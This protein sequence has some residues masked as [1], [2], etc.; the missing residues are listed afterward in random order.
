[1]ATTTGTCTI[2]RLRNGDTIYATLKFNR[3]TN[4]SYEGSIITGGF[5]EKPLVVEPLFASASGSVVTLKTGVWKCDDVDISELSIGKVD[6]G[7]ILTIFSNDFM[8]ASEPRNHRFAFQGTVVLG[9]IEHTITKTFEVTMI[10]SGGN[11]FWGS[12]IPDGSTI[13]SDSNP[14]VTLKASL[15]KGG[16]EVSDADYYVKWYNN[17]MEVHTGNRLTVERK[18]VNGAALFR[19]EFYST[20]GD[21]LLEADGI[22]VLDVAD[23]YQIVLNTEYQVSINGEVVITPQLY[24][25]SKEDFVSYGVSWSA[26]VKNNY[27]L[28]DVPS[29]VGHWNVDSGT[30]KFTMN[31]KDMYYTPAL[32]DPNYGLSK[33]TPI[34][35]NPIVIFTATI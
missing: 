3:A 10:S 28:A 26:K 24:S 35:Y 33:S 14:D 29:T 18:D 19:C 4:V 32:D 5:S 23:D 20:D 16:E 11:S 12:I 31:E 9:G 13:L 30:G 21:H 8:D 2:T 25:A 15:T 1:M 27:T 34:E 6:A 7:G 17:D 22:S